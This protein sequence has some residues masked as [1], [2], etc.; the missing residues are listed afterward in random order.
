MPNPEQ[1]PNPR[2]K[3]KSIVDF[4]ADAQTQT[5]EAKDPLPEL[6]KKAAEE[7]DPFLEVLERLLQLERKH[8]F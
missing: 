3:L 8:G 6:I 4:I 5:E 1:I 2:S 7:G